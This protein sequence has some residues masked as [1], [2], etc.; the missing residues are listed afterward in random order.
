VTRTTYGRYIVKRTRI[1][2]DP[3]RSVELARRAEARHVTAS[4]LI[5]ARYAAMAFRG[6]APPYG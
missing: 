1:H 4:Q 5:R 6:L 2:L 3:Q